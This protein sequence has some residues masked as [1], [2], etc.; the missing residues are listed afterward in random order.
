MSKSATT[1][2]ATA[3][4]WSLAMAPKIIRHTKVDDVPFTGSLVIDRT[5]CSS[6]KA[7]DPVVEIFISV[8]N[9]YK[10]QLLISILPMHRIA[11]GWEYTFIPANIED[12]DDSITDRFQEYLENRIAPEFEERLDLFFGSENGYVAYKAA[13]DRGDTKNTERIVKDFIYGISSSEE[14]KELDKKAQKKRKAAEKAKETATR[15]RSLLKSL[16]LPASMLSML[17]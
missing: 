3:T 8:R 1:T 15:N 17:L 13:I 10:K 12:G 9:R 7:V 6:L 4:P 14:Q 5:I 2:A 16:G 11:A